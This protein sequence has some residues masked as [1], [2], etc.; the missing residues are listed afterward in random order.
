[1]RMT[2]MKKLAKHLM[3]TC[4]HYTD[5]E[6]K[7]KIEDLLD[8]LANRF[9][10]GCYTFLKTATTSPGMRGCSFPVAISVYY[11]EK[12]HEAKLEEI[13]LVTPWYEAA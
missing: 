10:G 3:E 7:E 11:G 2:E 12:Y 8:E 6:A 9:Y 1:M 13:K 4:D 5:F